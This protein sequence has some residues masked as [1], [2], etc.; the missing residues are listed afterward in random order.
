M[1]STEFLGQASQVTNSVTSFK[2]LKVNRF[3]T[4]TS[5]LEI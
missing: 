2:I 4:P 5:N 1:V 3:N